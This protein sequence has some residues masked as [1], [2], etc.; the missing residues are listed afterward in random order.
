MAS[1][2]AGLNDCD[3][4][5]NGASIPCLGRTFINN[6]SKSTQSNNGKFIELIEERRMILG[7]TLIIF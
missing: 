2:D 3:G 7:V 5:L 4:G 6:S 1:L